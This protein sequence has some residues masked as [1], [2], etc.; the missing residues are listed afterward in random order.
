MYSAN[1][2]ARG[3]RA[4][5]VLLSFCLIQISF[6]SERAVASHT[7]LIEC[8]IPATDTLAHQRIGWPVD[9]DVLPSIGSPKI[10]VMA[11]DFP[12]EPAK[13]AQP[14]FQEATRQLQ[15]VQDFYLHASHG[16]FNPTFEV[17]PSVV[18]M[19]LASTSYGNSKT[20]DIKIGNDWADHIISRSALT[21]VSNRVQ[22]SSYA[23][24]IAIVTGGA[25]LS[26]YVGL[27]TS[28][29]PTDILTPSGEIH[30][31]IVLGAGALTSALIPPWKTIIHEMNH[32][33]GVPDLYL[34]AANGSY[35]GKSTGPFG[36]MSNI[37]N[38]GIDALTWSL[39]KFGWIN[40]TE[41]D[42]Y[43]KPTQIKDFALTPPEY[44]D[45]KPE[46]VIL[47]LSKQKVLVVESVPASTS[48]PSALDDPSAPNIVTIEPGILVYEIDSSIPSG[49]GPVHIIPKETP[50]T[51]APISESL[52]DWNRYA[53]AALKPG[54][55]VYTNGMLI[56]NTGSADAFY[57]LS[58]DIGDQALS[59]LAKI[60]TEQA[61]TPVPPD[62]IATPSPATGSTSEGDL[63]KKLE[64]SKTKTYRSMWLTCSKGKS[65]IQIFES[66]GKCPKGYK[67]VKKK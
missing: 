22:I 24:S 38:S 61:T 55:Y 34:Y 10:L 8:K 54:E 26:G 60:K 29:N 48:V 9:P 46:M 41:V 39:W 37:Q 45:G 50:I 32:L 35:Q 28:V 58:I 62:P 44:A 63:L 52:P 16:L 6:T 67:L 25:S 11:V 51:T 15:L 5:V 40:D 12:D 30:N 18:R 19:P 14:A 4:L 57:K 56:R 36:M 53:N 33:M 2:P 23:A 20:N 47:K 17:F 7:S 42:C 43:T 13:L 31:T 65:T 27:A 49:F 3:R 64:Q 1:L 66:T 59:L 21:A